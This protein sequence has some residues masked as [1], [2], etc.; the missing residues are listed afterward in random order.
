[1]WNAD[2]DAMLIAD[3]SRFVGMMDFIFIGVLRVKKNYVSWGVNPSLGTL[4]ESF[5]RVGER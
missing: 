3:R 2:E 4:I 1:V 5:L